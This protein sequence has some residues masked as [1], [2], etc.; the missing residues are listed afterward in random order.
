VGDLGF[1]GRGRGGDW[2]WGGGGGAGML[3]G[4]GGLGKGDDV[5]TTAAG[6][7]LQ[8]SKPCRI[9]VWDSNIFFIFLR[10][11]ITGWLFADLSF[12]LI[13]CWFCEPVSPFFNVIDILVRSLFLFH[14]S[15]IALLNLNVAVLGTSATTILNIQRPKIELLSLGKVKSLLLL[16]TTHLSLCAYWGVSAPL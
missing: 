14:L 1:D 11:L 10:L 12:T 15:P 6:C 3:G 2:P 13:Y 5:L 7:F 4:V 8:F 16:C 9:V